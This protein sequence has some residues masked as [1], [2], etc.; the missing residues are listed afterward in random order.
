MTHDDCTYIE[1]A[2]QTAGRLVSHTDGVEIACTTAEQ[3]L[4]DEAAALVAQI[5]RD[6]ETEDS[7]IHASVV[8]TPVDGSRHRTTGEEWLA[9]SQAAEAAAVAV[10][11]LEQLRRN[12]VGAHLVAMVRMSTDESDRTAFAFAYA[13]VCARWWAG[14]REEAKH[15]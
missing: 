15:V 4:R 9:L 7:A 2:C 6:I 3:I 14:R 13:Y 5:T 10:N 12:P 1:A 8:T 11:R